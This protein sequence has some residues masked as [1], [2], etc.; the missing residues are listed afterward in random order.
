MRPLHT[1]RLIIEELTPADA[2][3]M[4]ALLNDADFIANIA[5]RGVRTL[6]QAERYIVEGP[7]QS[8]T[9]HGYGMFAVRQRESGHCVGVCGLIKRPQLN[10][11]DIG[12]AFLSTARSQGLALEAAQAVWTYATGELGLQRL[13]AIVSPTNTASIRL[14]AKLGL[15]YERDIRLTPGDSPVRLYGWRAGQD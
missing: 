5:D 13:A 14:L 12:Y 2:P 9:E 11:T 15:H 8:Y 4:L 7:M 1:Q 6:A 3:F 10:D